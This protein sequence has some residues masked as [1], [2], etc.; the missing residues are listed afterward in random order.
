MRLYA[1][2][3]QPSDWGR[4]SAFERAALCCPQAGQTGDPRASKWQFLRGS[5]A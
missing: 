1:C 4:S 5:G 3:I 2:C